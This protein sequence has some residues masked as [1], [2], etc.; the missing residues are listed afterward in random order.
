MKSFFCRDWLTEEWF[1]V[2][3]NKM[4]VHNIK[5]NY[6]G[7]KVADP[8]CEIECIAVISAYVDWLLKEFSEWSKDWT[9]S[10]IRKSMDNGKEERL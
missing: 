1:Q 6:E 4:P 3:T 7:I 5:N 9:T 2:V 10:V 8:T